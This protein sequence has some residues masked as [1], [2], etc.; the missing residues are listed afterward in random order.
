M[1]LRYLRSGRSAHIL[2]AQRDAR[3]LARH[4]TCHRSQSLAA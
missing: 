3:A 2:G 4:L 1:G